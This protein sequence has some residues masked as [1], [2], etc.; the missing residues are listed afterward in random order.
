MEGIDYK[1]FDFVVGKLRSFFRD[2]SSSGSNEVIWTED[3]KNH[4]R[5]EIWLKFIYNL[6]I[7]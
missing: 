5:N 6:S 2:V 4:N 3:Y 7:D 1:N